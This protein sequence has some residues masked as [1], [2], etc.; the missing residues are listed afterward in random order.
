MYDKGVSKLRVHLLNLNQVIVPCFLR[1][2]KRFSVEQ[3][4]RNRGITCCRYVVEV[5]FASIKSWRMIGD[6]VRREDK[7]LLNHL[8][9]WAVGFHNLTSRDLKPPAV[10]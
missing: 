5:P 4:I 8:W 10:P 2:I 7:P 6:T 1:D 9:W 3:A